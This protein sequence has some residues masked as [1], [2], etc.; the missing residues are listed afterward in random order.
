MESEKRSGSKSEKKGKSA[1]ELIPLRG[2]VILLADSAKVKL[3]AEYQKLLNFF[4]GSYKKEWSAIT[5]L[6]IWT[7]ITCAKFDM[8]SKG[9]P[10]KE[11][12]MKTANFNA[13]GTSICEFSSNCVRLDSIFGRISF[14]I[15]KMCTF[16]WNKDNSIKE[17]VQR[18]KKK[19]KKGNFWS[20][21]LAY[22]FQ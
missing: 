9:T 2:I 16:T 20:V 5:S 11:N 10:S 7:M 6:W 15:A 12:E 8:E 13:D 14:V 19:I 21:R 18:E 22:M 17:R 1:V 3:C 4:W